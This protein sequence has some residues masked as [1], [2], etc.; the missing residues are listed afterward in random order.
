[1]CIVVDANVFSEVLNKDPKS[2]FKSVSD[3]IYSGL[4][5][6]VIGGTKYKEEIGFNEHE[7]K[8]NQLLQLKKASKLVLIADDKVDKEEND[9]KA[10][11][12]KNCNDHH[13]IA[14]LQVSGCKLL[15]SKDQD[16]FSYIK[17]NTKAKIY[18]SEKNSDLLIPSNIAKCCKP[19]KKSK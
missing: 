1:M 17:K 19:A 11:L 15:A 9:L 16:S 3:W 12:H 8:I 14:L 13:I 18:S 7:S 10:K 4:G 2:S 6:F 5:K